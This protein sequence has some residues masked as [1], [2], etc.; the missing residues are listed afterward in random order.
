MTSPH[1]SLSLLDERFARSAASSR[2]ARSID[3]H[4][5]L[6]RLTRLAIMGE[7]D[8]RQQLGQVLAHALRII[9]IDRAVVWRLIDGGQT[10]ALEEAADRLSGDVRSFPGKLHASSK[11]RYFRALGNGEVVAACADQIDPPM[12]ELWT[13]YAQPHGITAKLD[14]PLIVLGRTV[15]LISFERL[16]S[17]AP[18]SPDEVTLALSIANLVQLGD[19]EPRLGLAGPIDALG[20]PVDN[21]LPSLRSYRPL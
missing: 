6:A 20:P 15:G 9:E 21:A 11:P 16:G 7:Y 13:N 19:W 3:A 18:W 17:P 12:A 5:L 14:I 4:A 2:D 8:A 1:D 10:L